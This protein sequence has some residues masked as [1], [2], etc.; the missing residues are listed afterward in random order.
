MIQIK[1]KTGVSPAQ[2]VGYVDG[3]P[4]P[5]YQPHVEPAFDKTIAM[6]VPGRLQTD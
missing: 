4:C 2:P 3:R 6:A 5:Y 1:N